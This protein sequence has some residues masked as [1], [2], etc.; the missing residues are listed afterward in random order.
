MKFTFIGLTD[1]GR[2]PVAEFTNEFYCEHERDSH[3]VS[4]DK[5]IRFNKE[6]LL[7]RIRNGKEAGHSNVEELKGLEAIKR[8]KED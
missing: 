3:S 7:I 1:F 4:Y 8:N 6:S 5:I 2:G